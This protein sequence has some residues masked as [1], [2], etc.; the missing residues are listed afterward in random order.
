MSTDPQTLEETLRSLPSPASWPMP[1]P[2]T[3]LT[4]AKWFSTIITRTELEPQPDTF[5]EEQ[6]LYFFY[7]GV[8]Y[9]PAAM[10]MRTQIELPVAFVF[11][12]S[13]LSSFARYYPFDSGGM[14]NG[15]FGSLTATLS[16]F[17][18]LFRING[19]DHSVPSRMVYHLYNTNDDYLRGKPNPDLRNKPYPLPQLFEFFSED[20][21]RE[22]SDHRQ[23][24]IECQANSPV[25][26]TRGL[27]WVGFPDY[28]TAE[29][30]SLLKLLEPDVP[31][32]WC[33]PSH[34]IFDPAQVAAKLE[35][36][37]FEQVIHRYIKP[38]GY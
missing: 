27:I 16:S 10:N 36:K 26:L 38:P 8:F 37:A 18:Q 22:N 13:I 21:S 5:F 31:Q 35:Q 9:R 33:Y 25:P 29:F 17:D 12:P 23:C 7:G 11:A 1:L 14:I 15:K 19:G 34:A 28:F 6:L 32:Y 30:L 2:L 4:K 20:L 3:H 24:I